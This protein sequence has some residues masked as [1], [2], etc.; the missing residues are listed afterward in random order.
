[1]IPI[2]YNIRSLSVRK[3]TTIATA[4]GIALVVAVL[5]A[6]Q[7]LSNGIRNTLGRAGQPVARLAVDERIGAGSEPWRLEAAQQVGCNVG[8]LRFRVRVAEA[9]VEAIGDRRVQRELEAARLGAF[10][11]LRDRLRAVDRG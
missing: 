4:I 11:V 7:M 5:S 8:Q 6:S 3:T 9:Y 2:A 10:A 1:M